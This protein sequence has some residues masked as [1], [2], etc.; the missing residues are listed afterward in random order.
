MGIRYG[1]RYPEGVQV[2]SV[3]NQKGGVGKTTTVSNLGAALAQAGHATLLIDLDPQAHLS[4]AFDRMPDPGDPSVYTMLGGAHTLLDVIQP[5]AIDGLFIAPTNL[6]LTGAEQEFANE[7]GR[8]TLLRNAL[9]KLA[10]EEHAP[11]VV[12]LDCPPAL[13]LLS[14]NAL[15][16][17]D[18]V[19]IPVQAEFFALQGMAQLHDVLG[20]VKRRLNPNLDLIGILVGM[21]TKQRNLSRE[22]VAELRQHFGELVF[23]TLVRVNVRL[24][25]APSHGMTIFEYDPHCAGAE[26]F[27]TVANELIGRLGLHA[28]KPEPESMG[29][30]VLHPPQPPRAV[31]PL[32]GLPPGASRPAPEV[33]SE[34]VGDRGG[35]H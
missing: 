6:D 33:T 16:T 8:E 32:D 14:L 1:N 3:I 34:A 9:E 30:Y 25:E 5:T 23:D 2:L 21:Y 27:R 17:S 15:C 19:I 24:A 11:E 35:D 4:I 28:P 10:A 13:G 18:A 7:I 22:V 20:R 12:L 29:E 31:P 26:D